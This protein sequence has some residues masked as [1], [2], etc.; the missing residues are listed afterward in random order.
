MGALEDG[1]PAAKSLRR[2]RE[3]QRRGDIDLHSKRPPL[4]LREE[5]ARLPN[6]LPRQLVVIDAVRTV[7]TVYWGIVH[8]NSLL[9]PSWV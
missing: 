8:C 3:S 6:S 1:I 2:I 7:C 9:R 4:C 5:F